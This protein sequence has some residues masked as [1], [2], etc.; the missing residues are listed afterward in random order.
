VETP[1]WK[2]G[3]EQ[4]S[5]SWWRPKQSQ[6]APARLA[7]LSLRPIM[8][9]EPN[10]AIAD[11][12]MSGGDAQPTKSRN[13]RNE[14][15]LA[16]PGRLTE[17][18]ARNEAKLGGSG[19]CGQRQSSR[20]PWLGRGGK[21]AKRTQFCPS[22]WEWA[23]VARAAR[24]RRRAIVQNKPNSPDPGRHRHEWRGHRGL[25]RRTKPILRRRECA[26]TAA[27]QKD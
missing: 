8:Q 7:E 14:P 10:L 15:N 11:W 23:R 27:E 19:A 20:R 6:F 16:R 3:Y 24:P 22:A 26:L 17:G 4:T 5:R 1:L 12:K 13:V 18:I 25:L 2:G 9:N 21:R